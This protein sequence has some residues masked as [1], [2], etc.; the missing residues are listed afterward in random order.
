MSEPN[1]GGAPALG[2]F[3]VTIELPV[4][5]GDMDSFGHVN[6]VTYLRW[7]ESARIAYFRAAGVLAR[8]ESERVGP[9][10]ARSSIDYRIALEFPDDVRVAATVTKFGNTSFTMAMRMSSRRHDRAI[11][12]ENENV[13]VMV[14]YKTQRKVQLWDELRANILALEAK[15]DS[16]GADR[17]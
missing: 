7:F 10:L 2:R 14:D 8:M 11:A 15:A 12:A 3:P 13:I 6:N 4:Q 16:A 17:R 1:Q 9:I 5:W